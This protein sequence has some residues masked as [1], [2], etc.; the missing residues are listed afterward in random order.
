MAARISSACDSLSWSAGLPAGLTSTGALRRAGMA[1]IA[2]TASDERLAGEVET[3][4][5]VASP[6]ALGE[7]FRSRADDADGLPGGGEEP[8]GVG[9]VGARDG[10]G[11]IGEQVLHGPGALLQGVVR[12]GRGGTPGS[13]LALELAGLVLA[14]PVTGHGGFLRAGA[15]A[16]CQVR[17][18]ERGHAGPS[19]ARESLRPLS[20]PSA[21]GRVGAWLTRET[22]ADVLCLSRKV[23]RPG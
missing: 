19:C 22:L 16:S 21:A 5:V 17:R 23:A 1:R 20:S 18:A 4:P 8:G 15:H 13:G 10:G 9:R 11:R 6:G 3:P 14:V 2:S 12:A 7:E